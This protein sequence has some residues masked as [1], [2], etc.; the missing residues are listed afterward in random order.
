MVTIKAN[1]IDYNIKTSYNDWTVNDYLDCQKIISKPF[2][3]RLSFYSGMPIDMLNATP[4]EA[5][6]Q[7]SET[8]S[9]IE[10]DNL[11]A[12]LATPYTGEYI[13]LGTFSQIEQAKQKMKGKSL[14][15]AIVPMIE[16]YHGSDIGGECILQ[17]YHILTHYLNS[18]NKFFERFKELNEHEEDGLEELARIDKITALGHFPIVVK[19]GRE[20]GMTN[21]EV[22]AMSAE[23]VYMEM[24][25]DK[26]QR[27]FQKNYSELSQKFAPK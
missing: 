7:L 6:G 22:L 27:K 18:F 16:I 14:L 8:L 5:I 17:G 12:S 21:S 1:G 15:D 19:I 25:L 10:N 4:L 2:I 11:L 26:R 13:G 3:E 24:L 20:R 9:H 23:E